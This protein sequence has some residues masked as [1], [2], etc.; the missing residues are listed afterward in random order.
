MELF[1]EIQEHKARHAGTSN[2]MLAL[3]RSSHSSTEDSVKLPVTCSALRL[4][5]SHSEK[6]GSAVH[7][8]QYRVSVAF[9]GCV[10]WLAARLSRI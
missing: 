6:N 1:S 8:G 3:R 5:H 9:E 2:R 10:P 4:I 7:Y